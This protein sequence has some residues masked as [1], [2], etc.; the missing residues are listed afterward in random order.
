[1]RGCAFIGNDKTIPDATM[2]KEDVQKLKKGTTH[3][4]NARI[5]DM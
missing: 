3:A 1:M 4:T 2:K 5:Y